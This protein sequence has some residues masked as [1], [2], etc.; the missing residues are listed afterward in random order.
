MSKKS[1]KQNQNRL[2]RE[3]KRRLIAE[4]RLAKQKIPVKVIRLNS[5]RF[6]I[7]HII[8]KHEF[9]GSHFDMDEAQKQIAKSLAYRLADKLLE[10]EY[11]T[12]LTADDPYEDCVR[13]KA[14]IN[15]V[16]EDNECLCLDLQTGFKFT[17]LK[18][19]NKC[20]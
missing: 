1:Y 14:R 11:I 12:I 19:N 17:D 3:I 7:D 15:V 5:V 10:N 9:W 16:K 4:Q 8:Y 13:I 6:E 20:L 2:Y 18:E